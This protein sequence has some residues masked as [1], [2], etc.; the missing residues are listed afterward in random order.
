MNYGEWSKSNELDRTLT[1]NRIS[2][3]GMGLMR[4]I[5]LWVLCVSYSTGVLVSN[6]SEGRGACFARIKGE[7]PVIVSGAPFPKR[8]YAAQ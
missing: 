3:R 6:C 7:F 5:G 1:P 8:F 4:H 2:M